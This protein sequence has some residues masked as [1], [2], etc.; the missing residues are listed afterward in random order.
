MYVKNLAFVMLGA[1]DVDRSIEFYRDVLGLTLSGR[2]DDF[3]FLDTGSVTLVV[4]A[5]LSRNGEALSE[6][7]EVVFAVDSVTQAYAALKE[8]IAFT[9]E[10]RPVNAQNWAVN[11]RD[12]DGHSLSLY[13]SE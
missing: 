11:F 12:P 3:A 9:N 5:E 6:A 1:A 2:F 10:P 7:C 8:R 4:T 13:G